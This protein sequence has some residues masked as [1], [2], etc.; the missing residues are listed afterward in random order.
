[1]TGGKTEKQTSGS[2]TRIIPGHAVL[3]TASRRERGTGRPPEVVRGIRQEVGRTP[4]REDRRPAA[5]AL[6]EHDLI[7]QC[8]PGV[9][10]LGIHHLPIADELVEP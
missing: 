4:A 6:G 5:I 9:L 3:A 8:H 2:D 1:M 7:E 10:G